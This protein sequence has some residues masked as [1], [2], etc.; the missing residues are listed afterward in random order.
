MNL[1]CISLSLYSILTNSPYLLGPNSFSSNNKYQILQSY[2]SYSANHFCYLTNSTNSLT[3]SQS[4]FS[5]FLQSPIKIEQTYVTHAHIRFDKIAIF[6]TSFMC[7][8]STFQDCKTIY[9][10]G[11][12]I[13]C[14][15]SMILRNC[16]F[17]RCQ[18]ETGGAI[19][20]QSDIDFFSTTFS[21]CLAFL[22]GGCVDVSSSKK[23]VVSFCTF[24]KSIARNAGALSSTGFGRT[25]FRYNNIS[26]CGSFSINGA[27]QLRYHQVEMQHLIFEQCF[28]QGGTSG[29]ELFHNSGFA[30]T[31]L[32][33]H[34][35]SGSQKSL[36]NAGM[37]LT[38]IKPSKES[39]ISHCSFTRRSLISGPS[40]YL[41]PKDGNFSILHIIK[42]CFALPRTAELAEKVIIQN[43]TESESIFES[44]CDAFYHIVLPRRIGYIQ[45]II[46]IKGPLARK[47]FAI[48]YFSLVSDSLIYLLLTG[49]VIGLIAWILS[50]LLFKRKPHKR[51]PNQ[52]WNYLPL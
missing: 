33:F 40:I 42:C 29:I 6:D 4:S 3:I 10:Q 48:S 19:S 12:A 32:F 18:S 30:L 28:S 36:V 8:D 5:F 27:F 13:S 47:M 23:I 45:P 9:G 46:E 38:I 39:I 41:L 31:S 25:M 50:L 14:L 21:D 51:R 37:I 1:T 17:E 34:F 52:D 44:T 22:S 26:S 49:F 20:S 35:M 24:S 11:G 43:D 15:S 16:L 2:F 7:K